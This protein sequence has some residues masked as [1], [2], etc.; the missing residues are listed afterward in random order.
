MGIWSGVAL[1][2]FTATRA[3]IYFRYGA[4]V[5]DIPLYESAGTAA[6]EG[7]SAY[8]DYWFP[9]PPLSLPLIDLPALLSRSEAGYRN[10]FRA[11]MLI[12]DAVCFA[13]LWFFLRDRTTAN[14][15]R[16]GIALCLY[17][18]LGLTVGH[19]LLDRLDIV[20]TGIFIWSLYFYTS[21][22]SWARHV[23]YGLLLA[24][25]L[26]KL[27]PLFL[28]PIFMVFEAFRD[29]GRWPDVR[30][31][32]WPV[33]WI[34]APFTAVVLLYNGFICEKLIHELSQHG[35]RGIQ[36]ESN[37]ALPL[38]FSRI[39]GNWDIRV[40]YV[41][42]AFHIVDTG[43]PRAYLFL[44]KYAGF[45]S[46][47]AFYGLLARR[48]R[49]SLADTGRLSPADIV[50]LFYSPI[51]LLIVSQRVLSPQYLIWLIPV[52]CLQVALA[53]RQG[54]AIAGTAA[55][56][57]LTF[58]VF[59]IG[60]FPILDFDPRYSAA[61]VLRNALLVVWTADLIRRGLKS[62]RL[63]RAAVIAGT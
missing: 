34:A 38:I 62:L 32:L 10:V 12:F 61:L 30:R 8:C 56:Y 26:I 53:G 15:R 59:D 48:F 7:L 49:R 50:F 13:G 44:S 17:A 54:L 39:Q 22:R 42:G 47:L 3:L 23:A 21:T 37:W 41:H 24:G 6:R 36:I 9:Y 2:L 43:V 35:A 28:I 45:A 57:G 19:L 33:L 20:M 27:L 58:I 29:E 25:A 5:T 18:V 14:P 52:A 31:A 46:L 55:V 51:L 11:E 60:F 16:R 40:D 1:A 63:Q 4:Y